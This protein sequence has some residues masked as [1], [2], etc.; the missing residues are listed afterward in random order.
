MFCLLICNANYSTQIIHFRLRFVFEMINFIQK[1]LHYNLKICIWLVV[2][3]Y[4]IFKFQFLWLLHVTTYKSKPEFNTIGTTENLF[5]VQPVNYGWHENS[6]EFWGEQFV[7]LNLW[8][9][10]GTPWK[11]WTF[12]WYT[13]I[14]LIP[15]ILY[16]L[17]KWNHW[18][19]SYH[20]R[21]L[22]LGVVFKRR[23]KVTRL[24]WRLEVILEEI[25]V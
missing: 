18:W 14:I 15:I 16:F 23:T 13:C 19:I 5:L 9:N 8:H 12:A 4:L 17:R 6:L 25:P 24:D 10:S 1:R 22:F 20:W 2:K 7:L 11:P 3:N 21:T